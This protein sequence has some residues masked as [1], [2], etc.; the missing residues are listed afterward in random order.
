MRKTP[1]LELHHKYIT[2]T[3]RLDTT[4]Y[5]HSF[6]MFRHISRHPAQSGLLSSAKVCVLRGP[7]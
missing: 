5:Q 6:Y 7:F 4:I 3:M 1:S 2:K